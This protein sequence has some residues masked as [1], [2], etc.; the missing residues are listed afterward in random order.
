MKLIKIVFLVAI[1]SLISFTFARKKNLREKEDAWFGNGRRN[2]GQLCQHKTFGSECR[3]GLECRE[4]NA[5]DFQCM[6]V[7]DKREDVPVRRS[8]ASKNKS[9]AKKH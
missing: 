1:I 9:K 5:G 3:E 2:E 4:N 8:K 6:R 7:R